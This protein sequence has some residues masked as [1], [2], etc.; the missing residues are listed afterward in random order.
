M[1]VIAVLL[2]V[3]EKGDLQVTIK[4]ASYNIHFGVGL[5]ATDNYDSINKKHKLFLALHNPELHGIITKQ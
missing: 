4:I 2:Q 1:K 3:P 5:P